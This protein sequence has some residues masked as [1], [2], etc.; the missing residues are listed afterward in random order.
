[1]VDRFERERLHRHSPNRMTAPSH[2]PEIDEFRNGRVPG[3][4]TPCFVPGSVQNEKRATI[5]PERGVAPAPASVATEPY[6]PMATPP[7]V[8]IGAL[9]LTALPLLFVKGADKNRRLKM[10]WNSARIARL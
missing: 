3:T 9:A 8:T 1:M 6:P 10:F 7:A 4:I 2:S 5:W